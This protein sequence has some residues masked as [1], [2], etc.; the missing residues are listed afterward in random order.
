HLRCE[1]HDGGAAEHGPQNERAESELRQAGV[2]ALAAEYGEGQERGD[3]EPRERDAAEGGAK[4]AQQRG[5]VLRGSRRVACLAADAAAPHDRHR[6][7]VTSSCSPPRVKATGRSNDDGT[8][9]IGGLSFG[10]EGPL[11]L[12]AASTATPSRR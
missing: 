3:A 10:C 4:A 2:K 9:N 8:R 12:Y 11:R 1:H 6:V 5:K 7:E